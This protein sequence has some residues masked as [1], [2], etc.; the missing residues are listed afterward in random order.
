MKKTHLYLVIIGI[1][2]FANMPV[3]KGQT[4]KHVVKSTV[5]HFKSQDFTGTW[6]YEGI[7][8]KFKSDNLLKKAGG[9]LAASKIEK[10]LD[11]EL[12]KIG[13]EPGVTIFTFNDDDTFTNV[14]NGRKLGGKYSYDNSTGYITLKYMNHVPVKAKVS[15]SGDKMSLLFEAGGFLS[16]VTFIGS[17]SGISVIKSITSILNSYDGMMVGMELKRQKK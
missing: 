14:T 13:F 17:H 8:V 4:V 7:D 6:Y 10:N 2:S 1:L 16:F 9:S 12:R 11:T 3:V 15:G 5:N